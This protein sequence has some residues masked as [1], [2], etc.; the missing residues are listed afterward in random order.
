M[1]LNHIKKKVI[2]KVH[3]STHMTLL[4]FVLV[5]FFVIVGFVIYSNSK[6]SSSQSSEKE[7][8][9][10]SGGQIL[11]QAVSTYEPEGIGNETSSKP[12]PDSTNI[13]NI[14][15]QVINKFI[16]RNGDSLSM[17]TRAYIKDYI[18]KN[19]IDLNN[20][21]RMYIEGVYLSNRNYPLLDV[22]QSVE[23]EEQEVVNLISAS[24]SLSSKTEAMWAV[25][26]N[27]VNW[28]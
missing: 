20:V 27:K 7:S 5:I 19:G 3:I 13:M 28:N 10:S 12:T 22:G 6:S 9:S 17:L 4:L 18:D 23:I 15:P 14:K 26:A 2:P 21:Q 25:Y 16:V 11:D 1:K 8:S 24:K